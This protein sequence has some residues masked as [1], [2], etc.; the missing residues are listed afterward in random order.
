MSILDKI[1]TPLKRKYWSIYNRRIA[2]KEAQKRFYDGKE[3]LDGYIAH[4]DAR[5]AE[6][7]QTAIGGNWEKIGRL[8]FDFLKE[9]GLR[10]ENRMLDVGCGT[11]R[12]GRH[13]IRYLNEG[14]YTGIDISPA[15]LEAANALL[16]KENLTVKRTNLVLNTRACRFYS[17]SGFP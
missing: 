14:N 12:G 1:V 15:C 16:K 6:N 10:P 8:Q 7:P 3:Y 17:D 9:A 13:F 11:L 4:T 5:V 2:D